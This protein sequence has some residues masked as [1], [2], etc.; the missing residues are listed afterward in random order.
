MKTQERPSRDWA[1]RGSKKTKNSSVSAQAGN[2]RALAHTGGRPWTLTRRPEESKTEAVTG[3]RPS[4]QAAAR[5]C[6][7]KIGNSV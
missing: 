4:K 7:D 5:A 2:R 3:G 1:R 6:E